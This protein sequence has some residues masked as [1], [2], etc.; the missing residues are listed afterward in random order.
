MSDAKVVACPQLMDVAHAAETHK[1]MLTELEGEGPV[2][3][4]ASAVE[5]TDAA[6][7]QLLYAFIHELEQ[8]NR[9]WSWA[10]TSQSVI[11]AV[12]LAGLGEACGLA[13]ESESA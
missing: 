7:V 9:S 6:G 8:A 4:D 5:R 11:D 3:I 12:R 10:G 2:Q 1:M 13:A